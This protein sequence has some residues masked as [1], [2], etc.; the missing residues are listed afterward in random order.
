MRRYKMRKRLVIASCVFFIGLILTASFAI[1][2]MIHVALPVS[3]SLV[4]GV[5]V[6][7]LII[8]VLVFVTEVFES[9]LTRGQ[10]ALVDGLQAG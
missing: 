9:L 3:N 6:V 1:A 5:G 10:T 7:L 8:G 4:A 2:S